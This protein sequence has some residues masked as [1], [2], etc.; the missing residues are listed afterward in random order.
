MAQTVNMQLSKMNMQLSNM[1]VEGNA[2]FKAIEE[3]HWAIE[4]RLTTLENPS[5]TLTR[6]S[7]PKVSQQTQE[8][9]RTTR[10]VAAGFNEDTP[11]T[12]SNR[13]PDRDSSEARMTTETVVIQVPSEAD[14]ARIPAVQRHG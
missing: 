13:T 2:K 8:I 3:R 4:A 9:Q 10:A 1:E 7:D 11:R 12:R 6:S 14:Q 5:R